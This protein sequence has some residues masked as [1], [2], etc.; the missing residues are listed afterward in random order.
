MSDFQ[1][2]NALTKKSTAKP[3]NLTPRPT[4]RERFKSVE[5][6]VKDALSWDVRCTDSRQCS[7]HEMQYRKEPGF[8]RGIGMRH[9]TESLGDSPADLDEP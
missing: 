7:R 8:L 4:S 5:E 9:F 3:Q 2:S 1:E 6:L